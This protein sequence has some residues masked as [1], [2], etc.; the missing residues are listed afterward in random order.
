[1]K[2]KNKNNLE[3]EAYRNITTLLQES[4]EA[5]GLDAGKLADL[6]DVPQR[7]IFSLVSGDFNNLPSEPY[8]RGYLFKIAGILETDPNDLWRS[9]RQSA[10]IY[11]SGISDTLPANR[12]SLK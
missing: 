12:F 4:M 5:K 2:L 1:M 7:F 8:I 9:Y 3:S 11:T 6:T 10:E